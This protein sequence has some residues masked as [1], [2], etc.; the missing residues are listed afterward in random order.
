MDADGSNTPAAAPAAAG[1]GNPGR[2]AVE[3]CAQELS[4]LVSKW[5]EAVRAA[6]MERA[7]N[8]LASH[9]QQ[10]GSMPPLQEQPNKLAFWAAAL[11]NPLPHLGVAMEVRPAVLA[12]MT[13]LGRLRL[14]VGA[15]R[16]SIA[17]LERRGR[18]TR[19]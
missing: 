18:R 13:T 2:E 15:F 6:G 4:N 1:L 9:K 10:L 7:P 19:L 11:L 14:V 8:Q 5:E 17:T 12:E 3:R 16:E